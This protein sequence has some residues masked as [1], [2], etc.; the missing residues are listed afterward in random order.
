L[1]AAESDMAA[2]EVFGILVVKLTG[3]RTARDLGKVVNR[4][5]CKRKADS[6]D[7]DLQT[8]IH[9]LLSRRRK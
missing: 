2:K 1:R 4:E 5:A 6:A 7:N 8:I 9:T 3:D